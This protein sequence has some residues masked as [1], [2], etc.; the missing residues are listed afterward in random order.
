MDLEHGYRRDHEYAAAVDL[1]VE[2]GTL[3]EPSFAEPLG[4]FVTSHLN[5]RASWGGTACFVREEDAYDYGVAKYAGAIF[6]RYI[7][8]V[9]RSI[10]R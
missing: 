6:S 9:K 2:N 1:L 10:P 3:H 8:E 4:S 5:P 7:Y